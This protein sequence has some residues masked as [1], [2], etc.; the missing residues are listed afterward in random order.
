MKKQAKFKAAMFDFDGTVTEKGSVAPSEEMAEVLYK[1]ACEMPVAFC[2]GR[3]KSS[4]EEHGL[5][6]ILSNIE[7]SKRQKFLENLYLISENG[8]IGYAFNTGIDEYEEFYR[9]EWP[10]QF[11][12]RKWL[13]DRLSEL[14]EGL[15]KVLYDKHE[16]VIVIGAKG[17]DED[18]DI[19]N[20]YETSGQ[21]YEVVLKLLNEISPNYEDFVTIGNSGI[22]VLI[23]PKDGDKDYGITMFGKLLKEKRGMSFDA[24]FSEIVVVGDNPQVGG[25]DNKFLN[26]DYGTPYSVGEDTVDAKFPLYVYDKNGE[27]LLHA[28][29]TI[30]LIKELLNG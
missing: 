7:V 13:M 30:H 22:G 12:E 9:V 17:H 5:K 10:S 21:I 18:K 4:F 3:Q 19:T 26:G 14:T 2:T 20:V 1:L 11:A 15:G 29:G 25:N 6:I 16:V 24:K 28:P 27:K 23:I 8:A